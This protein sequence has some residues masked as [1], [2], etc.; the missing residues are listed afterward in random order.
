MGE[1]SGAPPLA[2]MPPED[3]LDSWKEIA[4]YLERDV[5]TVQR[6]EKREGMP[7]RRHVH[8]KLGSV[9]ASRSELDT[10]MRRRNSRLTHEET[11]TEKLEGS[12]RSTAVDDDTNPMLASVKLPTSPSTPR[13]RRL[14]TVVGF[15]TTGAL[16]LAAGATWWL[17]QRTD[18]LW[19]NPLDDAQFQI[20]TDFDG[21]EQA[22]A[23]SRDG[24]FV[25][26]ASDRVG[27]MDVWV[28]QV[29]TGRASRPTEL[30]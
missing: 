17:V 19:R 5:S 18:F 1:P 20:V 13:R 24:R 26:F 6:W 10:W 2:G 28:T 11:E 29:G 3:R 9:Y 12:D 23:V 8:E 15:L 16:L 22:A 25:A 27:P 21:T 4:A 14:S 30:L 7:V